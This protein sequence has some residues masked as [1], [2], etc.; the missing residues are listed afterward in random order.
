MMA[1]FYKYK[2]IILV[3][4]INRDVIQKI[5]SATVAIGVMQP[6][7]TK[8]VRVFGTGFI[9]D[10]EG[11]V[12][13]ASHVL[14][15]CIEFCKKVKD[16]ENVELRPAIFSYISEGHTTHVLYSAIDQKSFLKIRTPEGETDLDVV[17]FD[18]LAKDDNLPFLQI[19][20]KEKYEILDD[21]LMCGYPGGEATLR[22]VDGLMEL[23][24][25][26]L[27]YTGNISGFIPVDSAEKPQAI[28]TNIFTTGGSS[29]SPILDAN[30][31]SVIGIAQTVIGSGIDAVISYDDSTYVFSAEDSK[32]HEKVISKKSF[33]KGVA[34][35][36]P[37]AGISFNMLRAIPTLISEMKK[38]NTN[39]QDLKMEFTI[40]NRT[41]FEKPH[42]N[43]KK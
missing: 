29:G 15:R 1:N 21:V 28:Q 39:V 26:P 25:S 7:T 19:T 20:T 12:A 9:V 13:T 10:P 32:L 41:E 37:V 3:S 38:G 2:N 18:L 8:P 33:V 42:D 31:G 24:L 34:Q 43:D 14:K 4:L 40:L 5:K 23:R 17:V 36:G 30:D 6:H 16:E 27:L 35:V 11:Y 22:L